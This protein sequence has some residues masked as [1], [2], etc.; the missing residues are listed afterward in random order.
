MR[1]CNS[2]CLNELFT[3][4]GKDNNFRKKSQSN[5]IFLELFKEPQNSKMLHLKTGIPRENICRRKRELQDRNLLWVVKIDY[6][7]HTGKL[8]QFFT[9]NPQIRDKYAAD[10]K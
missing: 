8:T 6:C 3:E 10:K 7:P 4:K 9:T 2:H 5:K 1:T